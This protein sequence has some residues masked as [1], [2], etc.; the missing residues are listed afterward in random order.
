MT[1]MTN[2]SRFDPGQD[3]PSLPAII[4]RASALLVNAGSAAEMLEARDLASFVY[5]A[6]KKPG[7]SPRPRARA[8][9]WLLPR[10][11]CRPMRC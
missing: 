11:E 8:M 9:I 2:R 1:L 7:V 6:A 4:D 3:K 10:R 5:D